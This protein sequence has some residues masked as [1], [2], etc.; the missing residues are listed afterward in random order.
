MCP[1]AAW[2]RLTK[3]NYLYTIQVLGWKFV[4]QK[5]RDF[6][7]YQICDKVAKATNYNIIDSNSLKY[8]KNTQQIH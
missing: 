5:V 8:H 1:L 2:D 4:R 6:W 7:Q 3:C